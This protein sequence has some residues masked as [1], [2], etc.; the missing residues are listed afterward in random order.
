MTRSRKVCSAIPGIRV[1]LSHLSETNNHV[2]SSRRFI[3]HRYFSSKSPNLNSNESAAPKKKSIFEIVKSKKHLVN[4]T[5][6]V[7]NNKNQTQNPINTSS[8]VIK[9]EDPREID[10]TSLKPEFRDALESAANNTEIPSRRGSGDFFKNL[11]NSKKGSNEQLRKPNDKT[12]T[13]SIDSR[14]VKSPSA[15]IRDILREKNLETPSQNEDALSGS[16]RNVAASILQGLNKTVDADKDI[17][18]GMVAADVS[19]EPISAGELRY[20]QHLENMRIKREQLASQMPQNDSNS[21]YQKP[22]TDHSSNKSNAPNKPLT[23]EDMKLLA[24]ERMQKAQVNVQ[25]S[26]NKDVGTNKIKLQETQKKL[27][28]P[29]SGVSIRD[30]AIKASMK[31]EKV[32]HELKE[33]GEYPSVMSVAE[34]EDFVIDADIAELIALEKGFIVIREGIKVSEIDREH[35]ELRQNIQKTPRGNVCLVKLLSYFLCL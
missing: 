27:S 13:F 19:D 10:L 32:I 21:R 8:T 2:A 16:T 5:S 15:N 20:L 11:L 18:D 7:R 35:Q 22:S 31:V 24:L 6:S 30:F 33:I 9:N 23:I 4:D 29:H 3:V 12:S 14:R 1:G 25:S 17:D 28:F 34:Q 26:S